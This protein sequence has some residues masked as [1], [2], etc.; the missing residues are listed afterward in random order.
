MGE[1]N[2]RNIDKMS[3][4]M[5]IYLFIYTLF[6]VGNRIQQQG[7]KYKKK[8]DYANNNNT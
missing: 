7:L 4:D 5:F 2:I 8:V 6:K 1:Q 3:K